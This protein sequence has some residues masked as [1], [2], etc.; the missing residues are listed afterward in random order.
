ML[1]LS[2][3]VQT[4]LLA[5]ILS[6]CSTQPSPP[7]TVVTRDV[8]ATCPPGEVI[9]DRSFAVEPPDCLRTLK[10]FRYTDKSKWIEALADGTGE[11]ATQSACLAEIQGWVEAERGARITYTEL[12]Q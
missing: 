12:T 4:S 11:I 9:I 2:K 1:G 10:P 8:T 5:L 6:G 7:R 3:G